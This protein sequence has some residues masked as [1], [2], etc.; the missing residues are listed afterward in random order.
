MLL[1]STF[2][3]VTV[4]YTWVQRTNLCMLKMIVVFT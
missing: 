4:N 1:R 2:K 3:H